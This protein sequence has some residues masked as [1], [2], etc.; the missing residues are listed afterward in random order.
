[1]KRFLIR[2]SRTLAL[3]YAGLLL[4]VAGC[5]STLLY[6]PVRGSE[7]ELLARAARERMEPWRDAQGALIGWRRANPGAR[8]R[9]V[10]FHGNAGFALHRVH[11][12]DA[13]STLGGGAEWEVYI[14]EYPG[15]GARGGSPGKDAFIAA[16]RAAIESLPTTDVRPVFVLGE[17]IG[18]GTASAVAGAMPGKIA[19]VA[20]VIPFARLAEVAGEKFPILP[21]GLLLRDKFDNIAA[22]SAFTGPVGVVVASNDEVIGASQGRK[23]HDSL[24]TRKHL[25]VLEGAGHNDFPVAPDAP[26]FRELSD[27]L[28]GPAA[29]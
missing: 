5:Q 10:I 26:W 19:G 18:S 14:V 7:T 22:L 13:F 8:N 25:I 11:Y 28:L 4:L 23:L 3:I 1:M 12:A 17:S 27:F 15:Y 2:T 9:L 24:A 6:H 20:A 29:R 16:G 21:T